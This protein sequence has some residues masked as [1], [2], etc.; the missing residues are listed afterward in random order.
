MQRFL[1]AY[2][3]LIHCWSMAQGQPTAYRFRPDKGRILFHEK[4]DREQ[5]RLKGLDGKKDDSIHLS[6]DE[7]INGQIYYALITR[8]DALQ[9]KIE[10][11]TSFS[12]PVKVKYIRGLESLLA[13]YNNNLRKKDFPITIAP[14][15]VDA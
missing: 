10:A 15:L 5:E 11:D 3:L 14:E 9:E 13:G 4:V 6:T 1:L 7:T 2:L 8:V 12:N